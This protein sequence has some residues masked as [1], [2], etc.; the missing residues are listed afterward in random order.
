[1]E[2][3]LINRLFKKCKG[4]RTMDICISLV[5]VLIS[6]MGAYYGS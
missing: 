6:V 4:Y 3:E 2:Y 5:F 1:M